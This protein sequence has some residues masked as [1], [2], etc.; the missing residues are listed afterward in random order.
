MASKAKDKAF[1]DLHEALT[2]WTCQYCQ[3][4]AITIRQGAAVCS[5]HKHLWAIGSQTATLETPPPPQP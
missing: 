3:E 5:R 1:R 2:E 4:V